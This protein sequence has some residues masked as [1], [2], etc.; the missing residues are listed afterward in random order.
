MSLGEITNTLSLLRKAVKDI[1]QEVH[2]A[3]L[4]NSSSSSSP[5]PA[6]TPVPASFNTVSM[7]GS[8]LGDPEDFLDEAS[9]MRSI[10]QNLANEDV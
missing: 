8:F 2:D 7:E 3:Q 1:E 10:S 4:Y 6:Y 5:A 9:V